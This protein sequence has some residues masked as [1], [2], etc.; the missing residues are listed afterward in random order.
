M[1]AT[2]SASETSGAIVRPFQGVSPTISPGV[3][4]APGCVVVGDVVIESDS[5]VWYGSVLRGDVNAIRV[6]ARSNLQDQCVVH[7]TRDRFA[8]QIGDEVT[9][10]HHATVHGCIL[11]DGALVG[12]GAIVLDGARVGAGAMVGAG[13]LL[14]PGMQLESGMLALGVPARAVRELTPEERERN[15][16][17]TLGYVETARAHA[18]SWGGPERVG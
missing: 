2:T 18:A 17:I 3:W 13:A 14:P 1:G 6:G 11:D 15:R 7:V 4:L 8:C 10:G 16:Q 9:V 12:I 5:S